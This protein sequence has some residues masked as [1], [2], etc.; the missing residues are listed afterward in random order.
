MAAAMQRKGPRERKNGIYGAFSLLLRMM[1]A[2]F[3]DLF[4][5]ITKSLVGPL[6]ILN[7]ADLQ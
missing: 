7:F 2:V 4:I 1:W 5:V 6:Q 3:T